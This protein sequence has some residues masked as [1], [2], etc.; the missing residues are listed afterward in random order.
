MKEILK[1]ENCCWMLIIAITAFIHCF[2]IGDI[3]Y[4][5]NVDEMGMGY[6][7]WCL[8]K[9]GTDRYLN[10]FPVYLINFSGGQSALYAYL[11]A[12]FVYLFGISAAV[13]RIP[14]VIFSFI[15]LFFVVKIAEYI[16]DDKKIHFLS[17]FIYMVSPVFLMLSRIGLDCNLMIGMSAAFIYFILRAIE[18][19]KMGD[20]FVAGIFGGLLLYSYVISHMLLPVF[21][22]LLVGY[23][24]YI[25]KI[26]LKQ[27]IIMAIP[28]FVLAIPLMLMHFINIFGLEE[29][30]IGIFTIP[31]LYRYRSDDLSWKCVGKNLIGFFKTTLMYDNVRFN[32]I[33]KFGNMY[34]FSIPFILIGMIHGIAQLVNALKKKRWEP[35]VVVVLWMISAYL[36]GV[37][38]STSEGS[39]PNVY[40]VNSTFLMYL[41]F[42]VDGICILCRYANK[43]SITLTKVGLGTCIVIYVLMFVFFVKYYF[44]EYTKD[45]YLIDL[46]NFQFDDVLAY[47]ENELPEGVAERTTYI[48]DGN[49][50]YVY[51]LCSTMTSPYEYNVLTDDEPYTLWLWTQSYQNYRFN[52]PEEIDPIGN[53][54]VPETS[55][56]Y[57]QMYE[58]YGFTKEHIG[59]HYLFWNSMLDETD[60]NAQAVV[61]W[62]HGII[63]GNIILDNSDSTVLS[64]WA[65]NTTYGTTWDDVIACV[66]GKYYVAKKMEREDV[67]DI[68]QDK[69]L[70]FSGFHLTVPTEE[71]QK[72]NVKLIF[73]DYK[74]KVCYIEEY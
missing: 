20:F 22:L 74:N 50:T 29:M 34:F 30:K 49:Q 31:K 48:G 13:L 53:Y 71:I 69:E 60:S 18:K 36:T 25:R 42:I 43:F 46:F 54:I 11:C 10:S 45:T 38:I 32:S 57:I 28:S 33:K 44:C 51:Y 6:D 12:P 21:L 62:D 5:I 27:I 15:T 26:K 56:R 2:M 66:D 3:P 55:T 39:G 59:T 7:A 47:M 19:E 52:F 68:L 72:D 41:F 37:L 61:S 24:L 14:A 4:G 35:Y 1:K 58:Q 67:A 9:F 23:L 65:I 8:S 40:Q 63:D 16:W 17:A 73:I 64:G 70:L